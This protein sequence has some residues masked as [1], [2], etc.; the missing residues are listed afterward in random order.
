MQGDRRVGK[1]APNMQAVSYDQAISDDLIPPDSQYSSWFG[2]FG[3]SA[4]LK[5]KK[6]LLIEWLKLKQA[7][8]NLAL[9]TNA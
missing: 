4:D 7:H 3:K 2:N 8:R 5:T 6:E 1:P 9:W